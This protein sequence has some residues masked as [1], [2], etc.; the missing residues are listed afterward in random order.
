MTPCKSSPRL[1]TRLTVPVTPHA[2]RPTVASSA[3]AAACAAVRVKPVCATPECA[4]PVGTTPVHVKPVC[5][6]PVRVKPVC[7]TPL[8][9]KPVC[10]TPAHT[11]SEHA[12]TK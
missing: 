5:T 6:T 10:A 8:Y 3:R 4:K 1:V 9:V 12:M 7:T 11:M 2:A